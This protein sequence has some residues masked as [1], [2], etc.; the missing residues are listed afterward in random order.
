[1][2]D[3]AKLYA[4]RDEDGKYCDFKATKAASHTLTLG[5]ENGLTA[6]YIIKGF[7]GNNCYGPVFATRGEANRWIHA[8]Y[9]HS[10][11]GNDGKHAHVTFSYPEPLRIVRVEK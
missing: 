6:G 10:D 3:K 2:T 8:N 4:V 9:E 7:Q 11:R 5:H 1:M